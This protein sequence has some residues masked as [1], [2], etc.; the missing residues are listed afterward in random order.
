M[1]ALLRKLTFSVVDPIVP[2]AV[3]EKPVV[4]AKRIRVDRAAFGNFL[5]DKNFLVARAN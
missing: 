5:F 2:I 4:G 1:I 3:G